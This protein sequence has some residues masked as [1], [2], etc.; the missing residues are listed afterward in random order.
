MDARELV[1]LVRAICSGQHTV[2]DDADLLGAIKAECAKLEFGP[3]ES[4][5][6]SKA[7]QAVSKGPKARRSD[8]VSDDFF[9]HA[10]QPWA[11]SDGFAMVVLE[12]SFALRGRMEL[13]AIKTTELIGAKPVPLAWA[14]NVPPKRV[15]NEEV[16]KSYNAQD[17]LAQLC[18]QL[19]HQNPR[20]HQ[21]NELR[22]CLSMLE[23]A[24][25]EPDWFDILLRFIDGLDQV[26]IVVDLGS[27]ATSNP[28]APTSW[29]RA[30]ASIS[31]KLSGCIVKVVLFTYRHVT[32][33]GLPQV[34]V[35][36]FPQEKSWRSENRIR[37]ETLDSSSRAS[38]VASAWLK[39]IA[40]RQRSK[41]SRTPLDEEVDD[42]DGGV[43]M[44]TGSRKRF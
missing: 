29:P 7:L 22:R 12:G 41:R 6:K 14:L 30:F 36:R 32:L 15:P 3:H 4:R 26:F 9:W 38:S 16:A 43:T 11:A 27:M 21:K 37:S 19:F 44:T 20:L 1:E 23:S 28:E 42:Y 13:I 8:T 10:L 25:S 18:L 35:V 17:I 24:T 31:Q 39:Y 33:P 34:N 2:G 5:E 40:P